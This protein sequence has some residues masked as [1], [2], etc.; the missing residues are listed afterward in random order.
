[1]N[2]CSSPLGRPRV[3][4]FRRSRLPGCCR[5]LSCRSCSWSGLRRL[6]RRWRE[7]WRLHRVAYCQDRAGWAGNA[8][9]A[10]GTR[11]QGQD[12]AP[13]SFVVAGVRDPINPIPT[14]LIE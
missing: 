5:G 10:P 8:Q 9:V 1:M 6:P 4:S 3:G 2:C 14:Y 7:Q 12:R 13:Q 11:L